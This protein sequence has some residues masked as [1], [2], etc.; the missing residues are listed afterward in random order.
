M[1]KANSCDVSSPAC[2]SRDFL[3]STYVECIIENRNQCQQ[4]DVCWQ[5]MFEARFDCEW[6]PSRCYKLACVCSNLR[7]NKVNF[8][9]PD[10]GNDW[11]KGFSI[12]QLGRYYRVGNSSQAFYSIAK[13]IVKV[14]NELTS[15]CKLTKSVPRDLSTL[16][17]LAVVLGPITPQTKNIHHSSVA[18]QKGNDGSSSESCSI[19]TFPFPVLPCTCAEI[20]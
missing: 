8:N 13:A 11:Q 1:P 17:P 6:A 19:P 20:H 4:T 3:D 7:Y 18:T 14:I 5:S 12:R 16:L 2:Y 9:I 15:Q 10:Y